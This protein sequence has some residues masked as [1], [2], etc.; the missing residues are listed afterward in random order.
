MTTEETPAPTPAINADAATTPEQAVSAPVAVTYT[1]EDMVYVDPELRTV[2]GKVEFNKN[3]N[4]KKFEMPIVESMGKDGKPR[5]RSLT[6]RYY[7]WGTYKSMKKVYK[8]EGKPP[9]YEPNVTLDDV[10]EKALEQPFW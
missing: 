8:L 6:K 1:D 7:P 4:P 3:G 10:I 2:V 5:K 9:K